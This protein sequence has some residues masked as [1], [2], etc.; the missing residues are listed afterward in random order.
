[1]KDERVMQS[2]NKIWGEIGRLAYYLAAA[3][4]VVK[5]LFFG[6]KLEDCI[7]EYVIMIG[8]PI[9]QLFRMHQLKLAYSMMTDKRRY[10]KRE[11]VVMLVVVVVY[12][13]VMLTRSELDVKEALISLVAFIVSFQ[14]V[15]LLIVTREE[16][17]A[18]R[19]EKEFEED[20]QD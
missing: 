10:W 16:K 6:F 15:R 7:L 17:R 2:T 20:T 8:A 12:I 4:F 9:Y 3:S 5:C 18:K 14:A 11:A 13:V 1:M 19:L